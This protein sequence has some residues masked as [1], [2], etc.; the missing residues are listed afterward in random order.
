M[1]IDLDDLLLSSLNHDPNHPNLFTISIYIEAVC[2]I[3]RSQDADDSTRSVATAKIMNAID[4]Y[5]ANPALAEDNIPRLHPFLAYH[6]KRTLRAA[7]P[8]IGD[9]IEDVTLLEG[10]LEQR[11][12]K[13]ILANLAKNAVGALNPSEAIALIFCAATLI[14]G[15]DPSPDGGKGESVLREDRQIVAT[16]LSVCLSAQDHTGCWPL[17]RVVEEDKDIATQRL[18][19]TTFE[20]A[21]ALAEVAIALLRSPNGSYYEELVEESLD[22]LIRSARYAERSLVRIPGNNPP[23]VG[24]CSD[25]AY[26]TQMVESWTS[27]T[28]IDALI[29]VSQLRQE[30]LRSETLKGM[31]AAHPEDRA[32]PKWLRWST[33]RAEGEIDYRYPVLDYLDRHMVQTIRSDPR[34]LPS[35]QR[36]DISAL[37]FG[38]PGT[39]KTTIAKAVADG[40]GW[41]IIML[42]PGHFIERGLEYIEAQSRS[43]FDKISRLSRTVVVFDECDELFRDRKPLAESEQVRGITAFVTAS[44]LPKLQELHDRG[45]VVFFI[46]TNNFKSMDAAIKRGGRIDHILAV[47]PPDRSAREALVSAASGKAFGS[48]APGAAVPF[49]AEAVAELIDGTER[50]TRSEIERIVQS[51]ATLA[52]RES[53]RTAKD[54]RNAAHGLVK[55]YQAGL[56]ITQEEFSRFQ[57]EAE[58]FSHARKEG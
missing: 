57:K 49:L 34:G 14:R 24:W 4:S 45:Q 21:S 35:P 9:Q 10:K 38:P 31:D 36:R 26:G 17:G 58:D 12:R 40:L 29:A 44:M 39:S 18:E 41:P 11:A 50:F 43:V 8:F 6:A 33:F 51:L 52:T 13:N 23:H 32:W 16:S 1:A 2:G 30:C 15:G 54:A 48:T 5:L 27:A 7:S 20:V 3:A 22:R 56:T 37:L 46:C 42:S 47:G 28:V 55:E 53:W 19:I 25:H